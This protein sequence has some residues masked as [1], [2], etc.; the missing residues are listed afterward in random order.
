MNAA[1]ASPT[2]AQAYEQGKQAKIDGKHP[3]NDNPYNIRK[4][5][6]LWESWLEG[7]EGKPLRYGQFDPRPD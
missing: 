5:D 4:N 1:Q 6:G 3:L 2:P 7:W